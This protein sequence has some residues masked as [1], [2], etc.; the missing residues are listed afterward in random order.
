MS[1]QWVG[2]GHIRSTA[3]TLEQQAQ[4]SSGLDT[5]RPHYKQVAVT[6]LCSWASQ[7]E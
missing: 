3:V 2:S 7:Q 1:Q 4:Q 5:V 6:I